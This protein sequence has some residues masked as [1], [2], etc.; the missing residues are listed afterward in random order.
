MAGPRRTYVLV[1]GAWHGGWCWRDVA[2]RLAAAGH[3]VFTPTQTGLAE[4]K[5][6]LHAGISLDTFVEDI[7]NVIDAE[8]L[9]DI[10]LVGH[11][12][13]GRSVCGV[14]DRMPERVRRLVFLDS[15]LP[16]SGKSAMDGLPADIRAT[17]L[18]LAQDSSGGLSV[19][20]P[21]MA[22]FGITDAESVAWLE[23][24]LTPHPLGTYT[25][26]MNLAHPLGN[27]VP[28]TYIRCT[29]PTYRPTE[30]SADYARS[31]ADWQYLE[32]ATGHDAMISAPGPL[33]DMLL[34]LQ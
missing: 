5:H 15:G 19:P 24:R 7:V 17:R 3:A 6:L 27:G 11:S 1:H 26:P 8:E 4:R 34:A 32:L 2:S 22:D 31:R 25:T 23:R 10:Y 18:K 16:T 28:V 21:G 20:P 12:F 30:S 13:G 9:N 29:E 14:A 33:A